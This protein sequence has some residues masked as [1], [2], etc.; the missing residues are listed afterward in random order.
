[1]FKIFKSRSEKEKLLEKYAQLMEESYRL[2][3]TNRTASDAKVT[4]AMEIMTKIE[5]LTE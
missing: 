2:S 4:E 1:M 5:S 3:K